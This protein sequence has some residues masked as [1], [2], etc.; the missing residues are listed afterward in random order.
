MMKNYKYRIYPTKQQIAT[1]EWTLARCCDL[2]NT[3]LQERKWAW[4]YECRSVNFAGQSAQ[5]PEIKEAF[6]EYKDI[7]AQVLQDVLHRVDKTFKAFFRRVKSGEKA[8]HPRYQGFGR[9]DSFTYPQSGFSLTHDNRLCL[10]KIGT[11]KVKMHRVI[12]GTIKTCTIKREGS[13][14]YVCFACEVEACP[15]LPYTDEVVGIDLGVS[16]LATLSTGT[17]IEHPRYYRHAEKR[18]KKAQQALSRK[19]RGSKRRRKAVQRVAKLHRKV[20]RQR[21]NFLHEQSKWLI[22]TYEVI[23][24]EDLKTIN[25]TKAP[26]PKQDENGKYLPNG[27]SA[28]AGLN[29]SILDAGWGQFVQYCVYKAGYAGT[30][31]AFVDPKNTSQV[32]SACGVKGPHKDLSERTHTCTFCG[33]VLDRD[34]N[35]AMNIRNLW[36]GRNLQEARVS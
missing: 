27:A 30:Q 24:F 11:V 32:C 10:S 8:G 16:K 12:Q 6:P 2:Y 25:L 36:F 22:D 29:K 13:H 35:A 14:W 20:R 18:L 21:T 23:V 31:V 1:L 28:K 7:Y 15:K 26:K 19:K 34:H 33:V 5:L 3:A 9:Y 4:T 17:A